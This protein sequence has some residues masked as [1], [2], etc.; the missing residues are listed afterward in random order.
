MSKI[1]LIGGEKGG[2]GKSVVARLLAHHFAELTLPVLVLDGDQSHPEML[3]FYADISQPLNLED[4]T[5]VD[6]VLEVA[7]E[8]DTY[9]LV[10]LPSQSQRH[11][12]QWIDGSGVLEL[13]AELDVPIIFW[14]V[15]D[16]GKNSIDLLDGLLSNYSQG[17]NTHFVIVKNTGL[18]L[19]FSL[20][21]NSSVCKIA[22]KRNARI[23][24]LSE[25]NKR[26][27]NKIDRFNLSYRI[28]AHQTQ[29]DCLNLLERQRVKVWLSRWEKELLDVSEWVG[30]A[31]L[32]EE[33][34]SP[35]TRFLIRA[36]RPK[37][38]CIGLQE[39]KTSHVRR[40]GSCSLKREWLYTTN[41]ATFTAS[42]KYGQKK[43]DRIRPL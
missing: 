7:L 14:H 12:K 3:R 38:L 31:T 29:G 2:V 21:D 19:D 35:K 4:T 40:T 42:Q 41:Y 17:L 25:L 37:S 24:T 39:K 20:F 18:G 22:E 32:N 36:T 30:K 6:Q 23:L 33:M 9:V 5:S 8:K 26:V 34:E 1:H 27:M 16:D 28:A 43:A 11:L 10:D 15:I 13:S